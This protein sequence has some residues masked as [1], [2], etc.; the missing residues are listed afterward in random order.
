MMVAKGVETY[1]PGPV[2][3]SGN[4]TIDKY[5][6][7]AE[8]ILNSAKSMY[9]DF[10]KVVSD[11]TKKIPTVSD[12]ANQVAQ[13]NAATAQDYTIAQMRYGAD[14]EREL[15]QTAYQDT[16]QSMRDAGL[17]PMLAYM[18]GPVSASA[19]S[20]SASAAQTFE[21]AGKTAEELK[22][23]VNMADDFLQNAWSGLTATLDKYLPDPKQ[24]MKS[25]F[26]GASNVV[27]NI[28]SAVK[29][30]FKK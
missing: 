23:V 26:E 8:G 5:I 11:A 15:R 17:N 14:L 1:S 24:F 9:G 16:V 18:N 27:K 30:W 25:A 28:T 12:V 2:S 13:S 22:S 29:G 7:Q 20:G 3:T 4:S 21:G 6:Q 19:P 10:Y